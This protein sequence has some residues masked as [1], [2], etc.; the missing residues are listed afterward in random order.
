MQS[1]WSELKDPSV[2]A[3]D[4]LP[5]GAT[6]SLSLAS[7]LPPFLCFESPKIKRFS[8]DL[9]SG[10]SLALLGK[11]IVFGLLG[12][13][14]GST[15]TV[16]GSVRLETMLGAYIKVSPCEQKQVGSAWSLSSFLNQETGSRSTMKYLFL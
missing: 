16:S 10:I 3:K 5:P 9:I 7:S 15:A 8:G 14:A 4:S 6:L 2:W 12:F 1:H 11:S 13:P